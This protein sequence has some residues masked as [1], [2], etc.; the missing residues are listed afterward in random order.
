MRIRIGLELYSDHVIAWALDYPGCFADGADS[1]EAVLRVPQAV[2]GYQN[3]VSQHT[4][5]SWLT[6]LIDF[7]VRLEETWQ[8]YFIDNDFEEATEGEEINAWFRND[9]KPLTMLE[10]RRGIKVLS[11]SRTDLL[12]SAAGL[13]AEQ[14]DETHPNEQW[15]IRGILGHVANAEWYYLDAMGLAGSSK[16]GLA[17]DVFERLEQVRARMVSVLPELAGEN[18]VVGM[19]GE[20]WSP[21]KL[22]RRAAWHEHDHIN[23]IRKLLSAQIIPTGH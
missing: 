20:F 9:W 23:H 18:Q 10:V 6:D 21:R 14:L 19:T 13:S 11:F 5:D 7:D 8:V 3:W 17:E 12:A 15:P 2:A 4:E 16:A 1:T 22:L